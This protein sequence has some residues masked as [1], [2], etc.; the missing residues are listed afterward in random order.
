M[1]P[2]NEPT[3]IMGVSTVPSWKEEVGSRLQAL[4]IRQIR[5]ERDVVELKSMKRQFERAFAQLAHIESKQDGL[6]TL[7]RELIDELKKDRQREYK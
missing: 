4:E 5:T 1:N 6:H 3:Q 2:L 7:V